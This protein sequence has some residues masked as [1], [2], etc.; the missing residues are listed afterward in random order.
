MS[1][2]LVGCCRLYRNVEAL[3]PSLT[4]FTCRTS[5]DST[6]TVSDWLIKSSMIFDLL[7]WFLFIKSSSNNMESKSLLFCFFTTG[8][9]SLSSLMGS[10]F[11]SSAVSI[12]LS[13]VSTGSTAFY[14]FSIEFDWF[15]CK[16][17]SCAAFCL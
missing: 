14:G 17:D 12:N 11:S 7:I 9:I 4:L 10:V 3:I 8:S 5:L 13:A 1:S 15:L 2:F 6:V 16:R